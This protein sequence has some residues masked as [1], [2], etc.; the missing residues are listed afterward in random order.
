LTDAGSSHLPAAIDE[1]RSRTRLLQHQS[2][3]NWVIIQR[4]LLHLS[5]V[6][7]IIA[8]GGRMQPTYDK[9]PARGAL[10]DQT[11]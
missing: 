10:V 11:A 4:T 7:E 2:L 9:N 1:A 5:Q 3:T 6:I 8:T